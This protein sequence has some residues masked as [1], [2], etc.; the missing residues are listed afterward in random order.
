MKAAVWYGEKNIQIEE[1]P[2]PVI[3]DDEVLVKTKAVSICGS[4][5]HA[6]KGVSKRRKPPLVMGHEFSGEIIRTGK[7]VRNLKT[8]DR[9][10][11]EPIISCGVCRS[12]NKGKTNACGN[13]KLIGLHTTGAFAEYVNVRGEKC[14]KIPQTITFE[15]A[16]LVEPL[17]V[18]V[19]AV[20]ITPIRKNDTIVI[21][22]SGTIGLMTCQV[23]KYSGAGKIF[24][25][26]TIDYKLE[27]IKKLGAYQVINANKEDPVKKV[28][29]DG[30]VDVVFEA[31]GLQKTVQQALTMVTAA[32][33]VT[34]IGMLEA[35]MELDMLD[36]TVK[37]IEIRGSYGYTT[38]DFKQALNLIASKKVNVKPLITHV[39]PLDDIA[40]GFDILAQEKERVIKVVLK[41]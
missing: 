35:K 1:I 25:V 3:S 41:P 19:H 18:A 22:G 39:L 13:R 28:L 9:V 17:A 31:V 16:S 7:N 30:G 38:K 32:G 29:A 40:K 20:N 2:L 27:Q 21:I 10:V 4:D 33:E 36:V 34:I 14:H 15:E 6:Y 8:G 11:I 26:D 23:A 5:L 24:A 12:C 37:E